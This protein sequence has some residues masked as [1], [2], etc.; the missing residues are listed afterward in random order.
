MKRRLEVIV[1]ARRRARLEV[2]I[3]RSRVGAESNDVWIACRLISL[4]G[5][6]EQSLFRTSRSWQTRPGAGAW[7]RPYKGAG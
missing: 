2:S 3:R 1:V 5:A 7:F 4:G 6:R